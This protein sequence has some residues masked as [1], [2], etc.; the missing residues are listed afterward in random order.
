[1]RTPQPPPAFACGQ[2]EGFSLFGDWS[3]SLR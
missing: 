2:A 3:C 1:V